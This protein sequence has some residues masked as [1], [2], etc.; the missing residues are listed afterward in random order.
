[1]RRSEEEVRV[2]REAREALLAF[3]F[4]DFVCLCGCESHRC[5]REDMAA[6][7]V[8]ITG[9]A[10]QIG[11][12]LVPLVA[13]G[14]L[15]GEN[16]PV[17]L[18]LLD[19]EQAQGVLG[20]VVMEIEDGAYPLVRKVVATTSMAE[21]CKDVDAAFLVGG[22]P[23]LAGME[24]KDVMAKN[25]GIFQS[26]GR[27][28]N[29]HASPEI[30]VLVVA[31][32][33]NTNASI[34]RDNAPRIPAANITAMTRLD[35]NRA[36]GMLAKKTGVEGGASAVRN[37]IIWGNHSSTQVPDADHATVG[38]QPARAAVK[39]DAWLE[40]E[41]VKTVQQRGAAVIAARKLSSAMSAA[42]AA[43]DHMRSWVRG[44]AAG[45]VVSMGVFGN[46]QYGSPKDVCFSLP[47][48]C[49]GGKWTVVEGL[50]VSE[51]VAGLMKLSADELIEEKA[52][53]LQC[54]AEMAK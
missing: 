41:F 17:N 36:L 4:S 28:L 48:T 46:G 6:K 18:H 12:S 51:R 15:F 35:H 20:G 25:V 8:L 53:A 16:V 39:D 44:T 42:N 19:I 33:A 11:Y 22:F 29:E 54:L 52:L 38:G 43:V 24:R 21:A 1:V 49:A 9:A 47:C 2:L 45:E 30:K 50:S 7:T 13:S 40:S 27:S 10:G 5:G 14:Q 32:P 37:V 31:N 3:Y 26:M 23:R 34:L